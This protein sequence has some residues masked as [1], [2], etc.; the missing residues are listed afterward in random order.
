MNPLIMN[1][2]AVECMKHFETYLDTQIKSITGS[3]PSCLKYVGFKRCT[4]EEEFNEITK[5]R[6]M[7]TGRPRSSQRRYDLADSY[8]YLVKYFFEY[9]DQMGRTSIITRYIYLP[10]IDQAGIFKMSGNTFHCFPVISDKVFTPSRDSVFVRLTRDRNNVKNIYHSLRIDGKFEAKYVAWFSIYRKKSDKSVPKTTDAITCLAHYIFCWHGVTEAFRRY[11]G[12]TPV[13]GNEEINENSYPVEEWVICQSG[14]TQ[15]L[16]PTTCKDKPYVPSSIRIAIPRPAWN[17]QVEDLVAGF[18]YVVDHF[19]TRITSNPKDYDSK[20]LW[21]IL[22]GHILFSGIYGENKLYTDVKDHFDSIKGN[23]DTE[24]RNKLETLGLYFEDY[25]DLL[26]YLMVNTT[27]M[28]AKK[29]TNGL[30]VFGKNLE[31]L[32]YMAYPILECFV[33]LNFALSKLEHSRPL[34]FPDVQKC[35]NV[36]IRTGAIFK[37]TS[38]RSFTEVVGYSG[39]SKYPKVTAILSEQENNQGGARGAAKRV[40]ISPDH[41]LDLSMIILGSI[42]FFPKHHPTPIARVNP[43]AVIDPKTGTI[44]ENPKLSGLIEETRPYIEIP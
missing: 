21:M 17:K 42:L 36:E 6:S 23:L 18:F 29:K 14:Y 2:Y 34:S 20:P 24:I 11:A 3:L 9:T 44:L 7:R 25:F 39:D 37:I 28:L 38:G 27:L 15:S 40:T 30:N 31:V 19:P 16:G 26:N 32:Y 43:W 12:I 4:T 33:N 41:R 13:I 5:L 10:Y 35:L 8:T 22:M 1:G